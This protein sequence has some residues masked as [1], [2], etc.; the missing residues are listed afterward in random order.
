MPTNFLAEFTGGG[1]PKN[2]VT[3][4]PQYQSLLGQYGQYIAPRQGIGPYGGVPGPTPIPP[5]TFSQSTTAVPGLGAGA[6]T[7]ASNIINELQGELSPQALR[8]MQD[9]AARFG[10]SSGMP[11]S[12]ARPGSLAFNSNVLGNVETTQAEQAQGLKDYES[13][14]GSV[15]SQQLNPALIS[16]INESNAQLAAAPDPF[17]A[18]QAQLSNYYNA[19][20]SARG[21]AAGSPVIPTASSG[22][23][24]F[25]PNPFAPPTATPAPTGG[26]GTYDFP[27]QPPSTVNTDTSSYYDP[28]SSYGGSEFL[29]LDSQYG[30]P[31]DTV[32]TD[33]SS[34]YDPFA[35]F[36]GSDFGLG[37]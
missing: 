5:S 13:L 29:N 15:G 23:G 10:V 6:D 33:T 18:A 30:P 9:I 17:Q 26:T 2:T 36:G 11:G 35:D 24:S 3:G 16:Q 28:F 12:N 4:S 37:G 25:A 7:A 8:N 1:Q 34:Y 32:T 22:T 21:P 27:G 20:N 14:L 19:L 31:P